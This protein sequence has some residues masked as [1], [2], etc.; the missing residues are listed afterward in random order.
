MVKAT[1]PSHKYKAVALPEY[2]PSGLKR[3][4]TYKNELRRWSNKKKI[5]KWFGFGAQVGFRVRVR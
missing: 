5:K 1:S 4:D 2:D 3:E